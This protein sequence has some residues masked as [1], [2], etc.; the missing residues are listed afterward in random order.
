MSR[1]LSFTIF[2]AERGLAVVTVPTRRTNRFP[3]VVVHQSTDLTGA[4]VIEIDGLM[5]TSAVRTTIDLASKWKPRV[6]GKIMD[7]LVV[8][9]AVT[10]DDF[11]DAVGE[12]ARHGKPGMRT[13]H[14][15]LE[16]RTGEEFMGES[17]L[18]MHGLRL[19]REW[20]F[21]DPKLQYPLPWRSPRRGRVDFAYPAIRLII[22]FDGRRWHSTL[23]A[24]EENRL[25]DNHAQLAGWRVLRITYRMLMDEPEMV[26]A[27][28]DRAF[29][30]AS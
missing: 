6:I 23:D 30:L 1:Q 3:E 8:R 20:G 28:I 12:L 17:E 29:A 18:E 22:E 7:H 15:V 19:L 27:M 10:V 4:H 5:V 13:M 26:R 11:V 14:K 9:G 2:R 24:F 21:P 25:R 16:V